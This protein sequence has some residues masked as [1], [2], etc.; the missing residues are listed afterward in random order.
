MRPDTELKRDIDLSRE[1]YDHLV[2]LIYESIEHNVSWKT[3]FTEIR[4]VLDLKVVHAMVVDK[5]HG[6]LSYSHSETTVPV[7]GE[8]SYLQKYQFIDPRIATWIP[9]G[10][11][12]WAHDH[13]I[14]NEAYVSTSEFYQDF[15]LPHGVRYL[16]AC[17][18]IEDNNLSFTIGLLRSEEQG[19]LPIENIEF[20]NKLIPHIQ[21]AARIGVNHFIYSTRALVGHALINK[22]NQPVILT[23]TTGKI[24]HIND[25][26]H[27]L[28]QSTQL[29][30][31]Q[32]K[33]LEMPQ[34]TMNDFLNTCADIERKIKLNGDLEETAAN[35]KP[36]QIH[37]A[38]NQQ[39]TEKLYAFYT[40]LLPQKVMGSFGLR[41]LIML[42]FYHPE[43]T[44]PVDST[45]LTAAFGLSPAECKIATMLTEGYSVIEIAESLGKKE[46]TIRKQLT[47]IYQ[48]TS[49]TRQPELIKLLLNL[50]TNP[51]QNN[52]GSTIQTQ[53]KNP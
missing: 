21:R 18:I 7:D 39:H 35:F 19:P 15:L 8:L 52:Q 43:S 22:L 20:L 51:N 37:S 28:L 2:N 26:G 24:I 6:A 34:A 4:E 30:S 12:E 27:N 29:I 38:G 9:L 41:P 45:L 16:S 17:K 48:K 1:K 47:S 3:L 23:T 36:L 53:L 5:K 46:D 31:I 33:H 25:A 44:T 10:A 14:F 11:G 50:P 32:D 40:P 13:E 42:M 49:T